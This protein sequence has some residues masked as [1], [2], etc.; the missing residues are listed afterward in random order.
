MIELAQNLYLEIIET[1]LP[2]TIFFALCNLAVKMILTA[3]F[4]GGLWLGRKDV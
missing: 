3:A 4:G 2:V 1:V